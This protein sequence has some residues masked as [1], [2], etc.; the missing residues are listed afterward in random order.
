ML[1]SNQMDARKL[2]IRTTI[3]SGI[4][5][6][7]IFG[8]SLKNIERIP[9]SLKPLQFNSQNA[10][11]WMTKL[12]KDFPYRFTYAEP[13]KK[14]AEWIKSEFKKMG[15]NPQGMQFSEV[16]GTQRYTDLENIYVEKLGT[17]NP[18]QIISFAAHYDI[19]ETTVEGA[20]DDAA[21]V[22]VVMELARLFSKIET[23]KTLL[24]II[25]DS[26]ELGA[27]W[28][29]HNFVR[30]YPKAQQI[31]SHLNFDFVSPEKQTK[32]LTL[33][34]G[35]KEGYTPLWLRELAVD[36]V[37]SLKTVE[38]LD[39]INIMEHI[40]RALLIPP[41][42]HGEFL[43]AGIPA[44]NYAGQ[45]D[46]FAHVTSYYLH[47]PEDK[48]EYVL[49]S[50]LDD[51][52]K[53]AERVTYSIDEMNKL[54][55][56]FRSSSYWKVTPD[57]YIDGWIVT[58]IH[59]LLFIPFL[60]L[61]L[62]KVNKAFKQYTKQQR[63]TA[64]LNEIKKMMM[65]ISSLLTG[66]V[67]MLVLPFLKIIPQYENFPA[68]QKAPLLYQPKAIA[69]I[70]VFAGISI[71]YYILRKVFY[72]PADDEDRSDIRQAVHGILLSIIITLALFKNTYLATLM[73]LPPAYFWMSLKKHKEKKRK[74][75]NF[76]LIL[77]GTLSLIAMLL[78]MTSV[79]HIG[80]IYWYLFLGAT[81]GLFSAY[82][83]VIFL[84]AIALIIRQIRRYVFK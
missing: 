60:F 42:D 22:G 74:F 8:L 35:L 70:L 15:Y 19:A 5:I 17:K 48:A 75:I 34:D 13:R 9:L 6:I 7:L 82:A 18:E 44:F 59:I 81:Y 52:G 28:G 12:S 30:Q 25:T 65:L 66:Y 51:F 36:S 11:Q 4:L 24:F 27:F 56:N 69:F 63:K 29:A 16:I 80:I 21:G 72:A 73:L 2:F 20:M 84:I 38:A 49:A 76:L 32:I 26:E 47:T 57:R 64:F 54:P 33:C 58:I 23:D 41:A 37:R 68:T 46:D 55:E 1:A 10:H 77:M 14:A 45:T 62:Y 61:T 79:F 3:L 53:A 78:V 31:I 83:V 39:F 71:V 43:A 50:S 40:E 67:I